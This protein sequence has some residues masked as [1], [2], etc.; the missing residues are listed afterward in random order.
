MKDEVGRMFALAEPKKRSV[1][2]REQRPVGKEKD[3]GGRWEDEII[4]KTQN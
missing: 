1:S 3:E 4:I 2:V